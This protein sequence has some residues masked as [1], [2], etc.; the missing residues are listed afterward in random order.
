MSIVRM[1]QWNTGNPNLIRRHDMK[2]SDTTW[3]RVGPL[4]ATT[5]ALAMMGSNAVAL[6][7]GGNENTA[8]IATTP[9][10]EFT[11]NGDGSVTHAATGLVWKRCSEGQAWDGSA[12]T[13]SVVA[14]TWAQALVQADASTDLGATDWRLPNVKELES[15][16]E[17]RCWT[18]AIDSAVFPQTAATVYWTSSPFAGDPQASLV[19]NFDAGHT[20]SVARTAAT[21]VRLVRAGR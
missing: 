3:Q 4:A 18:P 11:D 2:S 13:G 10:A 9:T 8:V 16:V 1:N 5:L 15:L 17:A 12:C 6:C 14:L 19:V 7:A 21:A 20:G